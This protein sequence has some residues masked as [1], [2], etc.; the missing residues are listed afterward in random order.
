MDHRQEHSAR[1]HHSSA[2]ESA[3]STSGHLAVRSALTAVGTLLVATGLAGALAAAQPDLGEGVMRVAGPVFGVVLAVSGLAALVLS[4]RALVWN[5]ERGWRI[6]AA[7]LVGVSAGG[8]LVGELVL[9][10]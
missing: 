2:R 6:W 5:G 4:I 10:H 9:P 7:L 8:F 3:A 1:H